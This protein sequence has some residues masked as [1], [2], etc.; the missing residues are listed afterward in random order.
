MLYLRIFQSH[1]LTKWVILA[2]AAALVVASIT[3]EF[4]A[5]F[6]CSPIAKAWDITILEGH[7]L[8]KSASAIAGGSL[9]TA[10]DIVILFLPLP[11]L[12]SLMMSKGHKVAVISL[13]LTGALWVFPCMAVS[14]SLTL[15]ASIVPL[16]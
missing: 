9:N 12:G 2:T 11:I 1:A 6:Q 16:A 10:A 8:D 3:T 5:V 7:C 15:I 14:S 4:A 13:F